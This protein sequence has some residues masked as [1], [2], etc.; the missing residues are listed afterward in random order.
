V[1]KLFDRFCE[2]VQK[3]GPVTIYP[4]K[5]RIVCMVRVRFGGVVV[6]RDW[7]RVGLWLRRRAEHPTLL[8]IE[9]YGPD[10]Y[11][12]YFR[13]NEVTEMDEAFV[14][15]VREAYA[16]GCQEHLRLPTK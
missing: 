3:Y 8:R 14:A 4:Q 9:S 11:G 1:R 2:L 5:T 7:L 16:V 6:M 12:H 15:L 13:L 10:S